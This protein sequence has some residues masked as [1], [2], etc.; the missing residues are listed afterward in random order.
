MAAFLS[1]AEATRQTLRFAS[2]DRVEV[3]VPAAG[4][5]AAGWKAATVTDVLFKHGGFPEGTCAAYRLKLDDGPVVFVPRD[6]ES[7][8]RSAGR[9]WMRY[10]RA[11]CW[12][13]AGRV[14]INLSVHSLQL[15]QLVKHEIGD[16]SD[17][18]HRHHVNRLE[19]ASPLA[20]IPEETLHVILQALPFPLRLQLSACSHWVEQVHT[21]THACTHVHIY[22]S[23]SLRARTGWSRPRRTIP[24]CTCTYMC[25]HTSHMHTSHMH[26][27]QAVAHA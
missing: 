1:V 21:R 24:L 11:T 23:S 5:Y 16:V 3:H 10:V 7:L 18:F 8:V 9:R 19:S 20:T 22:A 6:M 17:R 27:S 14:G 4:N 26:T 12:V 25:M 13:Q 15:N 2:G